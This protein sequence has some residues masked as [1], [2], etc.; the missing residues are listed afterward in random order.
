MEDM[1]IA[2]SFHGKCFVCGRRKTKNDKNKLQEINVA[3]LG[4]AYSEHNRLILKSHAR[5]CTWHLD[6]NRN[7]KQ[8]AYLNFDFETTLKKG[9]KP[10]IDK[11]L[12]AKEEKL[13]YNTNLKAKDPTRNI[14]RVSQPT[15][16]FSREFIFNEE[17]MN[18]FRNDIVLPYYK[19]EKEKKVFYSL[20]QIN[21]RNCRAVP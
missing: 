11:K 16:F 2:H 3:S 20:F 1:L 14:L 9:F 6:A 4:Y 13:T 19:T 5:S 12:G 8:E 10:I 18:N 7:V 15:W 21:T 17:I